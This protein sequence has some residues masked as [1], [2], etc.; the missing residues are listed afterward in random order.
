[1]LPLTNRQEAGELLAGE[2]ARYQGRDDVTVLALPRGGVLVAAEV[3]RILRAPMDVFT[4]RKLGV[5]WNRELAVGAIASGGVRVL[6]EALMGQLG[7][8]LADMQ[9]VIESEERE[10]RRREELYRSAQG[11]AVEGRIVI[12]VDDG[13]ATGA[14]MAA[15]VEALHK[16]RPARVVVAVPVASDSACDAISRRADEC[17]CLS[18]P[19]PFHGV[20]Q[21]Y[22]DF[23]DVSDREV[24]SALGGERGAHQSA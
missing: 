14:T 22:H 11:I 19:R 12:V 18:R 17:V 6:D 5:P 2:L 24:L 7:I 23:H 21:W 16:L 9:G 3:A 13:L 20:G 4:V 8:S 1:M 15:A 10:L